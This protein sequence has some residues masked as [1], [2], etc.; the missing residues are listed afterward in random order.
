MAFYYS[1]TNY[2]LRAITEWV[3]LDNYRNILLEDAYFRTGIK[4]ML[5]ITVTSVIKTLTVP[6][7]IAELIF[8]L[9]N[10]WHAYIFR[11]LFILPT[12]VPGLVF[13][14]MWRQIYDPDTG[15]LNEVLGLLG[16]EGGKPPGWGTRKPPSGRSSG[17][18]PVGRRLRPADPARR[19]AQHQRRLLRRRQ[20]RRRLHLAAVHAGGP[21]PAGAAVPDPA[22]LR[23]RRHS[24]GLRLDLH[25]HR[26]GPGM[27]T[28]IPALQMYMRISTAISGTPRRSA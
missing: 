5:I 23:H 17:R 9:R 6:L 20:G 27:T 12:V 8:W 13:T 11:T 24:P 15:L 22:L 16:L 14:L 3:G 21:A 10:S 26:G 4:N 1:F 7:L 19:P 18:L 2:S 28:Y 25:P